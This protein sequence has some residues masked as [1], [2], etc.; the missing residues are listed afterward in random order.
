MKLTEKQKDALFLLKDERVFSKTRC[1]VHNNIMN[2][3]YSKGLVKLTLYSNGEF[4]E[5][6]DAG[7]D[8]IEKLSK[9]DIMDIF[10]E[11]KEIRKGLMLAIDNSDSLYAKSMV[12]RLDT[13]I[14]DIHKENKENNKK[15]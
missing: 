9:I 2:A 12:N 3:L 7:S 6:S 14:Y 4:W 13:I 5:I 8:I 1:K 15:I 10:E 11:L